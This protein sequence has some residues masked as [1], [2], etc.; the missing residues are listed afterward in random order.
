MSNLKS[1]SSIKDFY[2]KIHK[3][4][5]RIKDHYKNHTYRDILNE[6]TRPKN[7]FDYNSITED[8][9][10]SLGIIY[11]DSMEYNVPFLKE[12]PSGLNW[13]CTN[14]EVGL[15]FIFVLNEKNEEEFV[16]IREQQFRKSNSTYSFYDE[17]HRSLIT[18]KLLEMIK[19]DESLI[20]KSQFYLDD[21]VFN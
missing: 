6:F 19:L 8:I 1:K 3:N 17:A 18:K 2:D 21:K 13:T 10:C 11:H 15:Y 7:T 4:E 12:Y 5:L 14:T 9:C 16:G 20:P